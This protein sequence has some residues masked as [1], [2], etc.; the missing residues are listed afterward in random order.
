VGLADDIYD[1][2]STGGIA[3]TLFVGEP[4]EKPDACLAIAPTAGLGPG[5]TFSGSAGHAPVE[6]RRFQVRSRGFTYASADAAIEAAY[7][8]LSGAGERTLNFRRY[9]F[10][11]PVSTPAYLGLDDANRPMFT[12]NFDVWRAES[13]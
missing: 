7:A 4:P 3:T 8:I 11:A 13:T 9:Y 1:L 10:I 6:H 12:A 5:R 2:L